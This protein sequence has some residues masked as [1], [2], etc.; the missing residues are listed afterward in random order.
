MKQYLLSIVTA[1][2]LAATLFGSATA[3]PQGQRGQPAFKTVTPIKH[4]VVI[5]QENVSFDHYFGT[6]PYALNPAG[7][8][9][10]HPLPNTPTVNGLT[11]ALLTNNPNLANP[12]RFDRSQALTCDMN[13]SYTAEQQA[14]DHGLMDQFVQ[15]T[16]GG[17][18]SDK[19]QVMDYYDGNTVTA[20][21]NYAQYFSLNDNSYGT[22]F[23]PSTPG[24]INLVSGQTHGAS[25][26]PVPGVVSNGTDI[27]DTDPT[28]DAC[29]SKTGTTISMSGQNVGDLLN[30]KGITWGWFEGGFAPTSG[31][32]GNIVCGSSHQDRKSVV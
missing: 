19:T 24:A 26:S 15:S 14:F 13:H 8:P 16:G 9:K 6:Y 4:I 21:W 30:A 17:S 27:G 7:E 29:S 32:G 5:Y 23:G 1:L 25:P 2:V 10:F 28:Y 18:C 3:T 31:S 11:G 12:T 20:M 22:T